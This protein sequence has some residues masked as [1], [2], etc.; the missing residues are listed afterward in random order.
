[1]SSIEFFPEGGDAIA[2]VNNKIAFKATD[3]WGRPVKVKGVITS[4]KGTVVDSLRSLHDGMGFFY[5]NPEPSASY[6]AK[7]RDEKDVERTTPLP[8]IKPQGAALQIMVAG[9]NR[10]FQVSFGPEFAKTTDSVHLVG[11]MYQHEAFRVTKATEPLSIKGTIPT[12][13]LPTGILTITLFDKFWKPI[14]ERITYVN[15][16]EAIFTPSM[17]V[18]HWGLSKRARNEITISIPDSILTNLSVAVTDVA[19]GTDS[20]RNIISDLLLSSELKGSVYNAAYYFSNASDSVSRHLDL[21]MLTHGWR[22]FK[23]DDLLAGRNP[24]MLFGRDTAYSTLSGKI[25]GVLPSQIGNGGAIIVMMKQKNAEGKMLLVPMMQDGTFNDPSVIIFDT[26]QIY[27]QFQGK[28]LKDAAAQFMTSRLSMPPI[29]KLDNLRFGLWPDT[30]GSYRQLQLAAEARALAERFKVKT[31][32]NVTVKSRGKSPIQ[33]LDEKYTSA[34][35]GGDGQQFDLVN[36]PFSAGAMNIFT[37]LQGKVAGLQISGGGS[38][39]SLQWRGGAPQLFLDEMPTDVNL[40]SSLNVNDI[41]FVKVF[42]PPFFG[43]SNG[44]NGAIAIYT[45]RGDDRKL[46]P[47][48]GL[49]SA[50][51]QGYTLIREFYSPKYYAFAPGGDS[52]DVRTT[53][54]WNP[55]V[56]LGPGKK[57][58]ILSFYNND[59]SEA[60][61]VVIEGMTREGK[62]AHL[63]QIME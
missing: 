50:K 58:I 47:G 56:Q 21:V 42:R 39:T 33:L 41:A 28:T 37:Y 60:F 16:R 23:W 1:V 54:Y 8:A 30:S 53:L 11:T 52:R 43:S 2:G 9:T 63:E 29:K 12:K 18:K 51:I 49:A 19:I 25:M 45:R 55:Q 5:I 34:L 15:N 17:E 32:E 13:D 59:V 22:R 48:K 26:A 57:E 27:Y 20:S 24:K 40:I 36:D 46:E 4:S 3:Q 6:S 61:R 44:A 31:L 38:N 35:F 14:A 62:L 7:W 10:H